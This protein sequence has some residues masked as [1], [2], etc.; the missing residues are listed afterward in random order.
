MVLL[1]ILKRRTVF[2]LRLDYQLIIMLKVSEDLHF[3]VVMFKM[4]LKGMEH[5]YLGH[6]YVYA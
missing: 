3:V 6:S 5:I 4:L 1:L 2:N